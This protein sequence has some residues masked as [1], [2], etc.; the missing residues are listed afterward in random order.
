MSFLNN[1]GAGAGWGRFWRYID[2]SP[3]DCKYN[4]SPAH[5]IRNRKLLLIDF[6]KIRVSSFF[7][8][9]F[10][11]ASN[12]GELGIF[13]KKKMFCLLQGWTHFKNHT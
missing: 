3:A 5:R 10:T 13:N 9:I 4:E 8:C 6:K 1:I 12:Y 7:F 11:D 2:P